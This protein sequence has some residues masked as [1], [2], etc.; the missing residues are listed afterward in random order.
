VLGIDV[1][2]QMRFAIAYGSRRLY[3]RRSQ[4]N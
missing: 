1:L 4:G 3:I 2:S